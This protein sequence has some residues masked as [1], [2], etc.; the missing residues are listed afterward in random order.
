MNKFIN[1]VIA[2]ATGYMGIELI[3]LLSRHPRVK[4]KNICAQKSIG[5]SIHEFNKSLTKK[6]LPKIS[7]LD[8]VDFSDIDILFTALPNGEA[9]KISKKI[10]LK[11]KLID[12]S[13]DFRLESSK[14]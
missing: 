3:K 11:T 1:V 12:L 14:D 13:G 5:K 9:Q 6:K 10:N 7:R 4:I 8:N 2:G